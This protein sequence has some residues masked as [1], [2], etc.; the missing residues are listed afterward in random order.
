MLPKNKLNIIITFTLMSDTFIYIF[1][2]I[3]CQTG[4]F[5]DQKQTVLCIK[6]LFTAE[7]CFYEESYKYLLEKARNTG[8]NSFVIM[9]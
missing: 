1:L 8:H 6:A 5:D 4:I 2:K 3:N 9:L 7:T